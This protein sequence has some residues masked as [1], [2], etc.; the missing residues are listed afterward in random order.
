M[1]F[2]FRTAGYDIIYPFLY[3][4]QGCLCVHREL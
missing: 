2:T 1:N 3:D 4:E